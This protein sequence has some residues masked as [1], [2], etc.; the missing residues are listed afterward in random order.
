M[1]LKY[2]LHIV[3]PIVVGG[4]IYIGFRDTRLLF[5]SWAD[6]L[7]LDS[8]V[9]YIRRY[10]NNNFNELHDHVVYSIPGALWLYAFISFN[11]FLWL[12]DNSKMKMIWLFIPIIIAFSH[13]FLQKINLVNGTYSNIDIL[14][15]LISIGFSYIALIKI[16]RYNEK[17]YH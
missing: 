13:E 2:F 1:V 16:G 9:N 8:L 12:E 5:F 15:Y 4:L 10:M 11:F 6:I 17:E 14:Y 7:E 3:L